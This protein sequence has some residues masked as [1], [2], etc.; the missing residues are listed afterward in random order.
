MFLAANQANCSTLR[1]GVL[2]VTRSCGS[3]VVAWH[4]AV[5]CRSSWLS[6]SR[7]TKRVWWTEMSM[8]VSALGCSHLINTCMPFRRYNTNEPHACRCARCVL[9][10]MRRKIVS[11]R[12][13]SCRSVPSRGRYAWRSRR[14]SQCNQA[15]ISIPLPFKFAWLG[16]RRQISLLLV[17][18]HRHLCEPL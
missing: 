11:S 15:Q 2:P 1:C 6:R 16:L 3:W 9:S 12:P 18:I 13:A 17:H 10:S 8:S 14:T 7:H 5:S 4:C